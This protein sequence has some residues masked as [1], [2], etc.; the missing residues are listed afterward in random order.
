MGDVKRLLE[1]RDIAA[2]YGDTRILS[3]VSVDVNQ[4]DIVGIIGPNGAGKTTLLRVMAGTLAPSA[5][6]VA[7]QSNDIARTPRA[8]I[9][10]VMAFMPQMLT[11]SPTFSVREIVSMGRFPHVGRLES[12]GEADVQAVERAMEL[13]EVTRFAGRGMDELSGGEVQRVFFAQVL[14][15]E[16]KLL[17]MD[18]P[19]THLDITHQVRILDLVRKMNGDI[20][21]SVVMVLHD[22]NLASEYC[23]RLVLL[24]GGRVRKAGTPEE[25]IDYR[26][27]EEVY[28]T[29]VVVEKN[30]ISQKP[31]VLVVSGD[32]TTPRSP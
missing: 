8:D 9:A 26:I 21:L 22:L 14:A 11:F 29:V 15:Q 30:P 28:K 2:G 13:A 5:G 12:P 16:P 27:I 19:T 10:K 6:S 1:T 17:L 4:G 25:V 20:G 7:L 18:E 31:Y 24:D 23:H 32:L 3:D